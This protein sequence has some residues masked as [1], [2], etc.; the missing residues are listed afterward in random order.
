MLSVCILQSFCIA[1]MGVK[2]VTQDMKL[3]CMFYS[4]DFLEEMTVHA[5]G[6]PSAPSQSRHC[7]PTAGR[8]SPVD[9]H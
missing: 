2:E 9:V 5:P 4:M 6:L 7:S 3:P 1:S 8:I